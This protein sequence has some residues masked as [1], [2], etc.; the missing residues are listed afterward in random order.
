MELLS[1]RSNP[2][3]YEFKQKQAT[4]DPDAEQSEVDFDGPVSPLQMPSDQIDGLETLKTDGFTH[5]QRLSPR[6]ND[7]SD[8][9]LLHLHIPSAPSPAQLAFSVMQY[10]P[11]PLMVLNGLKTLVMANDAMRKLLDIEDADG[12]TASDDGI[13]FSD[14]LSGQ[15]LSQLGVDMLQD[16]RPV[17]VTWETFLDSLAEDMRSHAEVD[18]IPL[19]SESGEG[20]MT[21]TAERR[22]SL[23]PKI[24]TSKSK[25]MV[26][27]AVVEV[28]LTPQVQASHFGLKA[29]H[30]PKLTFAKTIITVW[31]IEDEKF[32]TLTF[33]STDSNQSSLPSSNGSS[34]QVT[35]T[36]KHRPF[37]SPSTGSASASY[38]S[39]SSVSSGRSSN[40][41]GSSNSSALT[42][43]TYLSMSASPFPPPGPPSRDFHSRGHSA[44]QK[45]V[46]MKEALINNTQVPILA[47]WKD[48]SLT[49]PNKAARRLFHPDADLT[50]IRDGA[51]LVTKWH[52]W[53]E[54]FTTRLDPSEY[55]IS[56]LV[57]SQTPFSS[58]KIGV[59]D[60]E[61]N[62]QIVFDCLGEAIRDESTGEFMAGMVTCRDIT[63]VTQQISDIKE[64]DEQRFQLICDSMPQMIWTTTPEGMHDWFSQRWYDYTGL[65]EEESLGMGW[66]LP[67]H[68]EDMSATSKRWQH[69]LATGAPYSTEYRCRNKDGDWRWMLGRALPLR[70]K[71]TGVIEKWYGTCTDIHEA[72]EARFAHLR[73]VRSKLTSCAT[74]STNFILTASTT[75]LRYSPCP[76]YSLRRRSEPQIDSD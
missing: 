43:P 13:F 42:S 68:P 40:Q 66:Q 52:I 11:C 73:M 23:G 2:S 44:L 18:T 35:K 60:P 56:I 22:D 34:R 20:D 12:D 72:V 16:G 54:T 58:F 64:K 71:Q 7:S 19:G 28:V 15:T 39:P 1:N 70:N 36:S 55:P 59:V 17:W 51:D 14:R 24:G 46:M 8:N 3:A 62:R 61:T 67:F 26:H 53:D 9:S 33:T 31:E 50:Q 21:P 25:S 69:S 49:I 6:R 57:R 10:L 41:G 63:E 32:F 45:V 27:D 74:A 48:E 38:S 29:S 30:L 37:G 47:M 65:T 4:D 5:G 75:S 76:S